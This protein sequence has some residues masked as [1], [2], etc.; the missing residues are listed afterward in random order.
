MSRKIIHLTLGEQFR[1]GGSAGEI[2]SRPHGCDNSLIPKPTPQPTPAAK[3]GAAS[4]VPDRPFS[5]LQKKYCPSL[6]VL[7]TQ[8][9]LKVRLWSLSAFY[10]LGSL[11]NL[12]ATGS[13]TQ[14]FCPQTLVLL[15]GGHRP[16]EA[17]C[18]AD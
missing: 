5:F 12:M 1:E 9:C 17:W 14:G 8:P 15:L 13:C 16:A 6:C 4:F 11:Q 7:I 10:P 2:H 3:K 18:L